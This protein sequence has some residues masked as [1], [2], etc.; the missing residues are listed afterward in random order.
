M[1]QQATS[2][3]T[4]ISEINSHIEEY[5]DDFCNLTNAPQFAILLKGQWGCGKSWFVNQYIKKKR[6]KI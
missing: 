5:L 6:K 2:K 4:Y 3:N 1:N